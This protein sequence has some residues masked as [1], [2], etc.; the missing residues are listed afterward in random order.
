MR[1]IALWITG[2]L[3]FVFILQIILGNSLFVLDTR[4][5]WSAPWTIVTA[6]F[7]HSGVGHLVSNTISL[8]IFGLILEGR[9]GPKRVL[10]LFLF[11][12]LTVNLLTP[13][14]PYTRVLGASGAVFALVGALTMLR[15]NMIIYNSYIPMP[16]FIA[17]GIYVLQDLFG[18]FY[19]SGT[20]NLAHIIGLIL[21]LGYGYYLKKKGFADRPKKK[22]ESPV[23]IEQFLDNYERKHGLR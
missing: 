15:P 18:V 4:Y 16:M 7:A 9:I 8:L 10:Y 2:T 5:I 1:F 19:P 3:F 17:A 22:K 14:T 11:A 6:M 13:L 12:G 21:G 20:A 23:P